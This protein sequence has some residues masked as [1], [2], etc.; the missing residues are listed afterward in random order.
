[1]SVLYG[2]RSK[3]RIYLSPIALIA[4]IV[5]IFFNTTAGIILIVAGVFSVLRL[6]LYLQERKKARSS[7][8]IAIG[9]EF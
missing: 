7:G 8:Q 3:F 1:M 5:T 9:K 6:I 2:K 4:G